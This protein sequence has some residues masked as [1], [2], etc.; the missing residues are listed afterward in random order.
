MSS[1]RVMAMVWRHLYNFRHSADRITDMFYWPAM[2]ILLWGLTSVYIREAG[3]AMPNLVVMLLTALVFWQVVW[4]SQYE[5]T[6]N[7]LEELWSEN[8]LNIFGSPLT[9]VEWMISTLVLGVVKMGLTVGFALGLV[10]LMYGVNILR[11]GITLVPFGMLLLMSGWYIGLVVAALIIR[12]GTRIQT[13][14][15][16]GV[17]LLAPFSAIYYP[18]DRLPIWAQQV[19]AGVPTSYV[20]EGMRQVLAGGG[21]NSWGLMVSAGLTCLYI[22]VAAA[23]FGLMFRARLQAG[24]S[25]LE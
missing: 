22:V 5:I 25:E 20:F 17:Y 7:L 10:Y 16:S 14:A 1:R 24:L 6:T 18:V 3:A 11:M 21:I 13:L 8:T 4:R 15:W 2:D 12:Y 9:V 19:A 23:F